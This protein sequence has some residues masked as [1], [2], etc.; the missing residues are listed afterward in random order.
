MAKVQ[1]YEKYSE[2]LVKATTMAKIEVYEKYSEKLVECLP[3]EDCLF[4]NKLSTHKLLPGNTGNLVKADKALPTQA[5]KASHFLN[6]V[7]KPAL[8]IDDTCSFD[9][10]LSVME[11]CDYIHVKNLA[12]KIISEII[13]ASQCHFGPGIMY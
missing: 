2:K 10:L 4:I 11:H 8:R 9:N 13:E 1:V 6:Y 5:D 12:C 7:I 3:M